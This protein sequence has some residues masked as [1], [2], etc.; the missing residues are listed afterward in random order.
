M[1]LQDPKTYPMT[2]KTALPSEVEKIKQAKRELAMRAAKK[3]TSVLIYY[4]STVN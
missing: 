4:K 3:K 1:H 2:Y